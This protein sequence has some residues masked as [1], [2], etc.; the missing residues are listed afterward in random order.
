MKIF[1]YFKNEEGDYTIQFDAGNDI[2]LLCV[3]TNLSRA[4][5]CVKQLN[6]I[7]TEIAIDEHLNDIYQLESNLL[8][9]PHTKE[10][11]AFAKCEI[12]NHKMRIYEIKKP[13]R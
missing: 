11:R 6:A 2:V 3:E 13:N 12:K 9:I 8:D 4:V 7:V 5:S 10:E 1:S